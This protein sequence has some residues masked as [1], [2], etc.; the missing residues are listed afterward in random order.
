MFQVLVFGL[1]VSSSVMTF[2]SLFLP[3]LGQ[4]MG[5]TMHLLGCSLYGLQ[6][7][8]AVG[9][10]M[11]ATMCSIVGNFLLIPRNGDLSRLNFFGVFFLIVQGF[12]YSGYATIPE[13]K[14]RN[15]GPLGLNYALGNM[16]MVFV[17]AYNSEYWV[18]GWGISRRQGAWCAFCFMRGYD[19][20][21]RTK[22][23]STWVFA[24]GVIGRVLCLAVML[25]SQAWTQ[26]IVAGI[27]TLVDFLFP[28]LK[29]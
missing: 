20:L 12:M 13:I 8:P 11:V 25:V 21:I 29:L 15:A 5:T 6:Y 24:Y 28:A 3:N 16:L 1:C 9:A 18:G 22:N 14:H 27:I 19:V 2:V 4:A 7:V 17:D 10:H 26:A 23:P